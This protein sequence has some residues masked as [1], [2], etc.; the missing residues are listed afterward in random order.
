MAKVM[1]GTYVD[2]DYIDNF[3]IG[4]DDEDQVDDDL[5]DIDFSKLVDQND[6]D[7]SRI[8]TSFRFPDYENLYDEYFNRPS[9]ECFDFDQF[10]NET[11]SDM[12]DLDS[13]ITR[14]AEDTKRKLYDEYQT[15]YLDPCNLYNSIMDDSCDRDV[16]INY[17]YNQYHIMSNS[18][19]YICAPEGYHKIS[20]GSN[21]WY[22]SRDDFIKYYVETGRYKHMIEKPDNHK[23]YYSK[24]VDELK[25]NIILYM[26]DRE[27]FNIYD[28]MNPRLL[29]FFYEVVS[30]KRYTAFINDHYK[31]IRSRKHLDMILESGD[32]I[33]IRKKSE[34]HRENIENRHKKLSRRERKRLNLLKIKEEA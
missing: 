27:S 3:V 11:F 15:M 2:K 7:D 24:Y 19:Y 10:I 17:V 13:V 1:D 32:N 33:Y 31:R 22:I 14:H 9:R 4:E 5:S 12:N 26:L 28:N 16:A 20:T 30:S 21:K 29:D 18:T 8:C 23:Y 25:D 6:Y 34:I